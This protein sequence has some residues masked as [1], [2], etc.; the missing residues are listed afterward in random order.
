VQN[1][2][3]CSKKNLWQTTPYW[4]D[5]RRWWKCRNC[6]SDQLEEPPQG[7]RIPPK[8]LYLDIETALMKVYVYDLYVPNKRINKE[9]IAQ[10]SFVITW[11]AAWL[12]PDNTIRSQMSGTVTTA[13]A[14]KQNDKRIITDIHALMDEADYVVTHNGNR[15]DVKVLNWRFLLYRLP[16]PEY[17]KIDTFALSNQ[18][19]PP[20]RGLEP[21]SLALGGEAKKGLDRAEWIE[22]VE[23]GNPKLLAKARRYC[24]GDVKEGV[25]VYRYYAEAIE[26]NGKRLYR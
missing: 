13:E 17:K 12:N 10:N 5:S 3:V 2:F 22:I 24:R 21:L 26:A 18:T 20:S 14:K 25:G 7:L 9:M 15:F 23:T 8:V 4:E 16:F 11:S 6:G 19:R 1:C